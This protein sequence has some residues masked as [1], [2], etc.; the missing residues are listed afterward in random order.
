MA[1]IRELSENVTKNVNTGIEE[2]IAK[3]GQQHAEKIWMSDYYRHR[4]SRFLVPAVAV[5]AKD[6]AL[7]SAPSLAAKSALF[8]AAVFREL[9]AESQ[10]QAAATLALI[11]GM[12]VAFVLAVMHQTGTPAGRSMFERLSI[13]MRKSGASGEA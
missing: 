9:P 3:Y 6:P 5:L 1:R 10:A 12:D 11:S 7:H 2:M 8:A 4:E 13:S